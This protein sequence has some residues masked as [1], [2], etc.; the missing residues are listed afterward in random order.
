MRMN[1]EP[2]S[3]A[4]ASANGCTLLPFAIAFPLLC[5][6]FGGCWEGGCQG[7]LNAQSAAIHIAYVAGGWA[8][9]PS[10]E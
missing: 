1:L 7:A 4:T 2:A 3:K 9:S 8:T 5:I 6:A 10:G